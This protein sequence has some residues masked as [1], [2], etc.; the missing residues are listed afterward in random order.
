MACHKT[1]NPGWHVHPMGELKASEAIPGEAHLKLASSE[2]VEDGAGVEVH[3]QD[4]VE[5]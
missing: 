1:D 2:V 5:W 3:E 4:S